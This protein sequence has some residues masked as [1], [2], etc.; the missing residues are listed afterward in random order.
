MT[1]RQIDLVQDSFALIVP[2]RSEVAAN[3]YRILFG[4]APQLRPLFRNDVETQGQK[5]MQVLTSVVRSLSNLTPL[6]HTIDALAERH[7][8]YGVRNAHYAP[9]GRA[10]ILALRD[11][12]GEAFTIETEEAWVDAYMILSRRMMIAAG[13]EPALAA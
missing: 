1:P 10:L 12:L 6:L 9:V 3:F 11:T 5:L 2:R 7:V 4:L 13:E 8:G